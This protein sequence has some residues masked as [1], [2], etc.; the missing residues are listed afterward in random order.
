MFSTPGRPPT[1]NPALDY[2]QVPLEVHIPQRVIC[3]YSC[4]PDEHQGTYCQEV[5][6]LYEEGQAV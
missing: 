2:L 6:G 3:S 5:L 4:R 1:D